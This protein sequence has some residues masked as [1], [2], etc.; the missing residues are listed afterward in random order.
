MLEVVEREKCKLDSKMENAQLAYI[1]LKDAHYTQ[2]NS[3]FDQFNRTIQD[4]LTDTKKLEQKIF[5][6]Q[7]DEAKIQKKLQS[8]VQATM[9]VDE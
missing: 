8:L 7:F 4:K 9:T 5:S 3:S 1:I 2:L 6:S